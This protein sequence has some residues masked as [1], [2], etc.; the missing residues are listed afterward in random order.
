MLRITKT[1]EE[2]KK[3]FL[4]HL[5]EICASDGVDF[6]L[7][8]RPRIFDALW[9]ELWEWIFI[10]DRKF[11]KMNIPVSPPQF[12]SHEEGL[13]EIAKIL[14]QIQTRPKLKKI[15]PKIL[16]ESIRKIIIQLFEWSRP[17]DN[18]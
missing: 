4:L 3:E 7:D 2:I 10:F 5:Q 14:F 9:I 6:S 15:T 16:A 11:H 12:A 13:E 1:V 8:A 18:K 17:R